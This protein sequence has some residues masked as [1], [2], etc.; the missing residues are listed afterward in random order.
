MSAHVSSR[1]RARSPVVDYSGLP[2]WDSRNDFN[3]ANIVIVAFRLIG[4]AD[5]D[6]WVNRYACALTRTREDRRPAGDCC[7]TELMVQPRE[8]EWYRFSIMKKT[9][10]RAED[11]SVKFKPGLVHGL[12]T[13]GPEIKKYTF[14]RLFVPR[15]DQ[16]A[17]W[18]F[19]RT[20]VGA[21][22]NMFAYVMNINPFFK[23]GA[24]QVRREMFE[25]Q[26]P[27]FC[28]ELITVALL[29]MRA[30]AMDGVRPCDSSPNLLY[31]KIARSSGAQPS[32]VN[33]LD[34]GV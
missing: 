19:L 17:G 5:V 14:F 13:D 20:Q 33:P 27:W 22:F 32:C 29:L 28:T 18:Q 2:Q 6:H 9:G 24:K 3:E 4:D 30:Q 1:D 12:L 7:H 21:P 34:S 11:G 10:E 25:N 23:F 8:G 31:R 16:F 15:A 26:Q